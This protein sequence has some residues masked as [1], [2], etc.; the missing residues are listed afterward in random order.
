[1]LF[2]PGNNPGMLKDA[3]IYNSDCIMFD[4]EDSVSVNEKDSAR[5]LVFQAFSHVIET[6]RQLAHLVPA[7]DAQ[8]AVEVPGGDNLSH[9]GYLAY[10]T[11]DSAG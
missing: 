11:G 3:G 4:L 1:M 2:V 9:V 5:F 6:L 10:G 8:T 7:L